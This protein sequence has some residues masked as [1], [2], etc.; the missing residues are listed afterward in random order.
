[1]YFNNKKF[2]EM[3]KNLPIISLNSSLIKEDILVISNVDLFFSLKCLKEHINYQYKVLSSISGVDYINSKYRFGVVYDILSLVNNHRLRIKTFIN[4]STF[5]NSIMDIFINSDWWERETF[6]MYGIHFLNHKDLRKILSDY[7]FE[8]HPQR[9]DF[10]LS[11]FIE[12]RYD[13]T[14]KR[15]VSEPVELAQEFRVFSSNIVW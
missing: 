3:H 15:V 4:E 12:L 1:M 10:P 5:V 13:M 11:G 9:K 7:G 8:G 14:K 6:D 2:N